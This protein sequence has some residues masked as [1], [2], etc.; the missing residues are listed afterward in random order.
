MGRF[1]F[2]FHVFAEFAPLSSH[3]PA[4]SALNPK[5]RGLTGID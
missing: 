4:L 2:G 3:W 1:D 5:A